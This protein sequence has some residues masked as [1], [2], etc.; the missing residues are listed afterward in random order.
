LP[1]VKKFRW[2]RFRKWDEACDEK[3]GFPSVYVIA[4][5]DGKP[6][7]IGSTERKN[8][9]F[10]GGLNG[11]YYADWDA[12]DASMDGSGN[13]VFVAEVNASQAKI[14]ETQLIYY[15]KPKYKVGKKVAPTNLLVLNH[16]GD[17]PSL[18]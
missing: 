18:C 17:C 13:F 8:G 11:R 9:R 7:Y 5:K 14:I 1:A 4:D 16:E 2:N 3:Y 10:A 12:L 6:L 15:C